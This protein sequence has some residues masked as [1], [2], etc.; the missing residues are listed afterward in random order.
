MGVK[1]IF[2]LD[3]IAE[4]MNWTNFFLLKEI[5]SSYGVKPIIG[6]I[7]YNEDVELLN[8]PKCEFNFWEEIRNLQGYHTI[9][10]M[11]KY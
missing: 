8:Y 10:K 5:F 3:D 1:Y 9:F 4:N 2:R 6:V 7:P 11:K